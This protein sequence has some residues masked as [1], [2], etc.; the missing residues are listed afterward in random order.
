MTQATRVVR[1]L[2]IYG[3]VSGEQ[4]VISTETPGASIAAYAALIDNTTNDPRALL[5]R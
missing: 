5:P 4:I 1:D 2:G 3:S